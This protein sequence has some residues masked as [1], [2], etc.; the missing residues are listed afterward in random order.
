MIA[1][2]PARVGKMEFWTPESRHTS[3]SSIVIVR[4]LR[5]MIPAAKDYSTFKCVATRWS[6]TVHNLICGFKTRT[7]GFV[8]GVGRLSVSNSLCL[9][10]R[11]RSVDCSDHITTGPAF[12]PPR[13]PDAAPAPSRSRRT[14][15]KHTVFPICIDLL[16]RISSMMGCPLELV[17]IFNSRIQ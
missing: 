9:W 17:C 13:A 6:M 10:R 5:E 7:C 16:K 3:S 14:G 11:P 1:Y 2:Y 4:R 12:L 8:S 15:V